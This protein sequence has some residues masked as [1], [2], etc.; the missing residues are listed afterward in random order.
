MSKLVDER[1]EDPIR[2]LDRSGSVPGQGEV[3]ALSAFARGGLQFRVWCYDLVV[4]VDLNV[5]IGMRRC[6]IR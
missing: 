3:P 5:V 2:A 6:G 4:R 1:F